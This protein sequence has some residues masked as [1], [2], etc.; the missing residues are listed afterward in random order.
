[1]LFV[2]VGE[3]D[4][5]TQALAT[6]R[7]ITIDR[8]EVEVDTFLTTELVSARAD[9]IRY[10]I[11]VQDASNRRMRWRKQIS[12]FCAGY[13]STLRGIEPSLNATPEEVRASGALLPTSFKAPGYFTVRVRSDYATIR[14]P[15]ITLDERKRAIA[16]LPHVSHQLTAAD[17]LLKLREALGMMS[18][19]A[20]FS[21]SNA[22]NTDPSGA[23]QPLPE[24]LEVM[25]HETGDSSAPLFIMTMPQYIAKHCHRLRAVRF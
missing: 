10:L 5:I 18:E 22:K 15:L 7:G 16:R 14:T 8:A 12:Y 13:T 23:L 24:G 4:L 3:L 9:G 19:A 6:A 21:R 11:D 25:G 17:R 20:A 1:M 2:Y